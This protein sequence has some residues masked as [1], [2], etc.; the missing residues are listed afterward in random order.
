MTGTQ[1]HYDE[2]LGPVYSWMAGDFGAACARN[3]ALFDR[4]GLAPSGRAPAVDL[5]CGHGVAAVPLAARGF[6]VVAIDFCRALLD[7]LEA[8]RGELRIETVEADLGDFRRHVDGPAA[9]VVCLG[10][11]LPHLP[12]L[13]SVERLVR[14]VAAALAPGGTFVATFRDYVSRELEGDARFIPVKSDADRILT[15]ML[16]YTPDGV[17]VHDLLHTRDA[18]GWHQHVSSYR[19]LRL[20]PERLGELSAS[21]GLV[22]RECAASNGLVTFAATRPA[23]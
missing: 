21:A 18:A 14:D 13:G 20:D 7:E 2:L 6:D 10:D 8:V 5:G 15:C 3:E 19:K 23:A 22:V 1:A 16:E 17:L 12:D 9:A 4:L 11:T